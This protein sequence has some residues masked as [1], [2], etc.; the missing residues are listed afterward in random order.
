MNLAWCLRLALAITVQRDNEGAKESRS[1]LPTVF[2]LLE[3]LEAKLPLLLSQ[4]P[5][6]SARDFYRMETVAKLVVVQSL[7]GSSNE[8]LVA[9][10]AGDH[11]SAPR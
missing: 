9:S 4:R 11:R 10:L 7:E 8:E 5:C 6:P 1:G 2:R 3:F